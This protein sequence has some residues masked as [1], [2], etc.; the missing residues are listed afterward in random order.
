MTGKP[1]A[2]YPL[3]RLLST[4]QFADWLAL[5][6]PINCTAG[7][8]IFQEDTPG[9]WVYLVHDGKVRIVRQSGSREITLGM[10]QPGDLFGEYALLPPGRNT[11]TCRT[12]T[13]TRLLRLPLEPLRVALRDIKPVWKNL[14]NWLRL[15]TLLHFQRGRAFLGFMS[16]ESGL[17]F[18]DR[19]APELFS[20][21]QTIQA[22]GLAEDHWYVIEQ[23]AVRQEDEEL[24]PGETFGERGLFGDGDPRP[25]VALSDVRCQVLAREDFDP[26]APV[27]SKVAQSYLPQ[28]PARPEAHV[29]VSQLGPADCGLAS[30]SMVALR[31]GLKV[32]VEELRVKAPPGPQGLNVQQLS[33]LAVELGLSCTAV[34]VSL[35]RVGQV[36]LPAIAHLNGGHYVVLHELTPTGMVVGDPATGLVSWSVP[37]LAQV[38]TGS[39]L[40]CATPGAPK[41][42]FAVS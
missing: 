20:A 14:K 24:G 38:A 33:E 39:L 8:L 29:W 5:G 7:E 41:E 31:L 4:T 22:N 9:A 1:L 32:S 10:L 40:L 13:A 30:L 26:A 25:A 28:L 21:G 34:R 3:L 12:S 2:R 42:A 15:H 36:R 35:D 17:K 6:Q 37:F 18:L 23:G 27:W 16:A 11:A 19:L